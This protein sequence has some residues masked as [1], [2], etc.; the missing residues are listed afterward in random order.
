MRREQ[1]QP[2]QVHLSEAHRI[3]DGG[4]LP[5]CARYQ[6]AIVGGTLGE[7]QLP[8]AEREHRRECAFEIELALV[9]LGEVQQEVCL[10][11]ARILDQLARPGEKLRAAERLEN[12]L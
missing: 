4:D 7:P 5:R 10:D 6:D 2:A 3:D 1:A 9:D 8:H 11:A 12:S